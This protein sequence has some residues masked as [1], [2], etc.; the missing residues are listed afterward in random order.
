MDFKKLR[1]KTGLTQTEAAKKL[2]INVAFWN[3]VEAGVVD[4]PP[5]RFKQVATF[6]KVPLT[7]LV[8]KRV[9][10]FKKE[11]VSQIQ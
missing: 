6:L 2:R 3:R 1:E 7:A 5:K 9:E 8:A 4:L 10:K 11:L